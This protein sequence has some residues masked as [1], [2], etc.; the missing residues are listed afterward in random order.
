[1]WREKL[2]AVAFDMNVEGCRLLGQC[3]RPLDDTPSDN[4]H[5]TAMLGLFG[6]EVRM[7]VGTPADKAPVQKVTEV[8]PRSA[9]SSSSKF[10]GFVRLLACFGN[11]AVWMAACQALDAG[12]VATIFAGI[13]GFLTVL[14][15]LGIS[16][17]S[18]D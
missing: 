13:V 10:W 14:M 12:L 17:S 6:G 18:R 16:Q 5:R 9:R 8:T 15:V 11:A 7:M 3:A 4:T 1:M 2:K